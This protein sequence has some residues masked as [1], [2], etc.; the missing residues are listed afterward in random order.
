[1]E[2]RWLNNE[3][4]RIRNKLIFKVLYETGMRIGELLLLSKQ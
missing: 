2:K 3:K 4:L 1:M